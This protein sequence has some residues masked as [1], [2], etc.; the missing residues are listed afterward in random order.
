MQHYRAITQIG[1][2]MISSS[3]SRCRRNFFYTLVRCNSD[4]V[5]MPDAYEGSCQCGEVRYRVSGESVN[6]FACHCTQCQEQ[7]S[8][9]FGMALW[10][11]NYTVDELIG[12]LKKWS[13]RTATGFVL[14]AE[15][16]NT[17]GTRIFH[18]H[19]ASPSVLSIKPGTLNDTKLLNPIAH[20]WTSE[21]QQWMQFPEGCL[22]YSENPPGFEEMTDAW[23]EA[24]KSYT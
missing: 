11:S 3:P 20:I 8:S 18:S 4:V 16:C 1:D 9:A 21:S 6:L 19:S 17:C 13:R 24:K 10:I 7:S 14:S 5:V 2:A 15:F 22:R 12:E 23:H